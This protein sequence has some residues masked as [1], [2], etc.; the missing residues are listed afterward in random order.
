MTFLAKMT[1]TNL[2][3]QG[4]MSLW[5]MYSCWPRTPYTRPLCFLVNSCS[6]YH[7]SSRTF[8]CYILPIGCIPTDFIFALPQTGAERRNKRTAVSHNFVAGSEAYR[9]TKTLEAATKL[10]HD[11][12]KQTIQWTADQSL[13]S[14]LCRWT[15]L[16]VYK[17]ITIHFRCKPIP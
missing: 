4:N 11:I 8:P 10:N 16:A 2:S 12:G 14:K 6:G 15:S 1:A 3:Q 7:L 9:I 5:I 17:Q 13:P